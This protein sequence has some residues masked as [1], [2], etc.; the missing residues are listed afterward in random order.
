MCSE[1]TVTESCT[2]PILDALGVEHLHDETGRSKWL[3][4]ATMIR[5]PVRRS[6]FVGDEKQNRPFEPTGFNWHRGQRD[7]FTYLRAREDDQKVSVT[8]STQRWVGKVVTDLLSH[9]YNMDVHPNRE[10]VTKV[11]CISRNVRWV[12]HSFK[13]EQVGDNKSW[14][15]NGE[16]NNIVR[17]A[18]YIFSTT[19]DRRYRRKHAI[20]VLP[21][22]SAQEELLTKLLENCIVITQGDDGVKCFP[23]L[24]DFIRVATIDSFQGSSSL[25]VILSTVRSKQHGFTDN[26]ERM[27]TAVSRGED[28]TYIFTHESFQDTDGWSE[29]A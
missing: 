3:P 4:V 18:E 14:I 24:S 15:N 23:P 8:L 9:H 5:D 10:A 26:L 1:A 6:V 2:L 16:A 25:A 19:R 11:N 21:A 27:N 7:L 22:Y 13:D 29:L 17:F 20:T 12:V 28:M